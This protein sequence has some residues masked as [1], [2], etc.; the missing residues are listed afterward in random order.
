LFDILV[1][2]LGYFP[3]WITEWFGMAAISSLSSKALW[4]DSSEAWVIGAIIT[5]SCLE[6]EQ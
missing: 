5:F 2:A 3:A 1:A 4:L 6:D